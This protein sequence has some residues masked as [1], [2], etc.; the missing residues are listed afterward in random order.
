VIAG[1]NALPN[2]SFPIVTLI[3]ACPQL[4]SWSMKITSKCCFYVNCSKD[5]IPR[6]R[7]NFLTYAEMILPCVRRE[8]TSMAKKKSPVT[9]AFSSGN[10]LLL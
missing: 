9:S 1:T 6:V 3:F 8:C 2:K 7:C 5:K 4:Y 10:K